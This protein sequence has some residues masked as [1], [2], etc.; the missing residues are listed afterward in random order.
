MN[1]TKK[2]ELLCLLCS[3][4][5]FFSF[6]TGFILDENSAG[7]GGLGGDFKLIW[8]NLQLFK[9]NI[10]N[11]LNS[12]E[13][14]DSRTPIA[15]ILHVLFNPFIE[16]KYQ[17]RISVFII[18]LLCP[19]IFFLILKE[20]YKNISKYLAIFISSL[21]LLSPYFRTTAFWGLGEN[22]AILFILISYYLFQ[23]GNFFQGRVNNKIKIILFL[24]ALSSSL[25][26]YFDQKLLIIPLIIF[27]SIIFDKK[28]DKEIKYFLTIF[29]FFFSIPF[30]YL[31][32][33]W[34]GILPPSTKYR[35]LTEG[36]VNNQDW[37]KFE[38][39][40]IGYTTT[41]I[42]FYFFPFIFFQKKK[43]INI[44]FNFFKKE[45]ISYFILFLIYLF[46]IIFNSNFSNI[47]YYGNGVV[48]KI[49]SLC[50]EDI[51]LQLTFTLLS[52]LISWIILNIFLEKKI[53]DKIIIY[54]FLIIACFIHPVFQEYFDPIILVLIFT[55]LQNR[56]IINYK[57]IFI[58]FLYL[59]TFLIV[60]NTYYSKII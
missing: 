53:L 46:L 49:I 44:F 23:K 20:K 27:I 40:N 32:I 3:Y 50:L 2:E 17:F 36:S 9:H 34:E 30:L 51:N 16:T 18:S 6:I 14:N 41:I 26:V 56:I 10:F 12:L 13:Y 45:N 33:L 57:N 21:I 37:V 7:A 35:G 39:Y 31:V 15:Y 42:A 24:L 48:R 4:L 54:Y 52:F 58:L 25:C 60:S 28:I 19:I 8:K 1:R 29:Y 22:Y 5:I 43:I 55:F 11:N 38:I 59:A 47:G